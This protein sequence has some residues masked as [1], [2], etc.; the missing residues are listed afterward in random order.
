MA[1]PETVTMVEAGDICRF[2]ANGPNGE[3]CAL[4]WAW[5]HK[6][7]NEEIDKWRREFKEQAHL[8]KAKNTDDDGYFSPAT[9]NDDRRNSLSLIARIINRTWAKLGYVRN[10][11]EC[12]SKGKLRPVK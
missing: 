10:N 8:L 9:I 4:G 5:V 11:P 1:W 3:H 6:I 7:K 2:I 12:D